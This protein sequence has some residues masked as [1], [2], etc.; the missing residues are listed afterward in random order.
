VSETIEVKVA[1]IEEKVDQ[2]L[3]LSRANETAIKA[4]EQEMRAEVKELATKLA[5]LE[6]S[7]SRI[8]GGVAVIAAL[9]NVFM[10]IIN[11]MVQP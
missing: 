4:N 2:L 7:I 6:Q 9:I 5:T 10:W 3:R 8:W 1:R 11:R